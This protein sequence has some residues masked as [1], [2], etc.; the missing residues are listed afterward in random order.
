MRSFKLLS[1]RNMFVVA[2]LCASFAA[3]ASCSDDDN[4]G[5]TGGTGGSTGGSAGTGGT[6][7]KG[8][9]AGSTGGSAGTAGQDGGAG[10]GGA[11]GAAGAGGKGGTAGAAGAG[12]KG[13]TAGAAGAGG[14]AGSKDGGADVTTDGDASTLTANVRVAHRAPGA[15]AVDFCVAP[16]GTTTWTGPVL[17]GLGVTTGLPYSNVTKYVPLGAQQYDVRIVAPGA[18]CM[19]GLLPDVTNLPAL[20]AGGSVT[21]AAIG[22]IAPGDAGGQP[23]ALKAFIDDASVATGKA[24]LRFLHASSGTPAVDVGVGGGV[25]FTSVFSNVTFGNTAAAAA[26]NGYVETNP[27]TNAEI[28]ARANGTTTDV[29]AIKGANLAAGT[30]ATAF[31]IGKIGNTT[32]PLKVLLCADNGA[33]NGN[34][35]ACSV[36]GDAPQRAHARVAHLSPDAP[37]VDV[38]LTPTGTP[39]SGT[40][41]LRTLGSTAGLSYPQVTTYVDL[42]VQGYDLRIVLATATD[43]NTGAVP[44]RTNIAVTDGLYAT[45]AALGD[46]M[47]PDAGAADAGADPGFQVKVFADNKAAPMPAGN[48][49]LRF[50]HASPGT[51]MV[52]VGLGSAGSF[53]KVFGNVTFGN[54]ATGTGIDANGFVSTAPLSNAT[55]S[56]RATGTTTDAIVVN[57]VTIMANAIATAFAIGNKT[58]DATKPLKVLLCTDSAPPVGLL[59]ACTVAP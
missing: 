22:E 5:G 58:G 44:D 12:G 56:A 42:P 24:K 2:T 38:C 21:L 13:G 27:L 50:I 59:S 33:P 46:L 8:G 51:G 19:T 9:S 57:N 7:G 49:S 4:G 43:C 20:P 39:F 52:D 29:L 48:I 16:H 28:S 23:F 40:P 15:P 18:T 53:T 30:I 11:S 17:A 31:A 1:Q 26:P 47:V 34:L 14:A 6:T 54:V 36:V 25:L 55:I 10:T 3:L 32:S 37:A 35:A 45:I 41:L